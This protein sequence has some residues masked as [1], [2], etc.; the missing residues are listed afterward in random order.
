MLLVLEWKEASENFCSGWLF[1][2]LYQNSGVF[3]N[4]TIKA[5]AIQ[6]LFPYIALVLMLF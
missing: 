2:I 6:Q 5:G 3:C 1:K 4:K